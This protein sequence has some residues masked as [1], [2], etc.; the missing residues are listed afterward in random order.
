MVVRGFCDRLQ[1]RHE[2]TPTEREVTLNEDEM[3]ELLR[4]RQ[5][6]GQTAYVTF[7]ELVAMVPRDQLDAWRAIIAKAK[8]ADAA[9]NAAED[10]D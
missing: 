1:R 9:R 4:Q 5:N 2:T 6:N 3:I 10:A 7:G 8:A